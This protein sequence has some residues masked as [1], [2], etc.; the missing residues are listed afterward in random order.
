MPGMKG[1]AGGSLVRSCLVTDYILQITLYLAMMV[2]TVSAA[3]A[4]LLPLNAGDVCERVTEVL[5]LP[6][7]HCSILD[8]DQADYTTT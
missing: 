1:P 3:M 6:A 7:M 8:N 2:H 5:P 4:L